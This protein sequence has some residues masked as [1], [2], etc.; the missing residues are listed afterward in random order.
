MDKR[1][2]VHKRQLFDEGRSYCHLSTLQVPRLR[3]ADKESEVTCR[4]CL[5]EIKWREDHSLKGKTR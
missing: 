5:A 2:K 1:L 4:K 3:L